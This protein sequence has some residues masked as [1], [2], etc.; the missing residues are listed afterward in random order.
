MD[1]SGLG[2]F[3]KHMDQRQPISVCGGPPKIPDPLDAAEAALAGMGMA[4]LPCFF[5]DQI[6][7]LQR[8]PGTGPI[9]FRPVWIL[10]HPDLKT[11]VRVKTVAKFLFDEMSKR[12][13]A[14]TGR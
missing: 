1:W 9:S 13:A 10:T 12:T 4:A 7:G 5:A 3:G 11:V 8:I 2:K 6:E 14:I